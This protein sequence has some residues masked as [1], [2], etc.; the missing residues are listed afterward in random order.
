MASIKK[1]K[2]KRGTAWRVQY[3][4]P[5]GRHRTKQPFRTKDEAIAWANVNAVAIRDGEWVAPEQKAIT[6]NQLQK[7]WW[8]SQNAHLKPSTLRV[9][10]SAWENRVKPKW[11]KRKVGTIRPSEVQA[12]ADGI[13]KSRTTVSRAVSV[14]KG[15][16]DLAVKD[17]IIKTNP[18]AGI[19]L[20]RKGNPRHVFLTM[21]QVKTLANNSAYPA[22]V[23]I[24]ATTGL[25]WGEL[26]ALRVEDVDL[27][28][29]RLT[30]TKSVTYVHGDGMIESTP[31]THEMRTVAVPK[32][33]ATKLA[34]LLTEREPGALVFPNRD[35]GYMRVPDYHGWLAGAIERIQADDPTFPRVTAHGLRHVA[36][37]L[38]VRSGASVKV[39]QR[40]LGHKSAAMTLDQ[41]ADLFDGDLDVVADA[42]DE[43]A[44]GVRAFFVS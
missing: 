11:G 43:S 30:I 28:R 17:G 4:S 25:R 42:L 13:G 37:G 35:G 7:S 8:K 32:F 21:Q 22:I 33:V 36:A 26:A 9:N 5:D 16:L 31:K 29:R 23:W 40:Q 24:L 10:K 38:M 19:K 14:L 12:W 6:V 3:V 39:V 44:A 18:A 20:P 2:T 1:Y 15:V 41:Y 34:L 27:L